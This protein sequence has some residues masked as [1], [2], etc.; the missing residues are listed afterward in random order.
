LVI[1]SSYK[2]WIKKEIAVFESK[3]SQYPSRLVYA[4]AIIRSNRWDQWFLNF[5]LLW[6]LMVIFILDGW[7]SKYSPVPLTIE[8]GI[9]LLPLVAMLLCQ[10]VPLIGTIYFTHYCNDLVQYSAS[11]N[12]LHW[13]GIA[14]SWIIF[15]M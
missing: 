10:A 7:A 5:F 2:S 6:L 15:P 1:P 9:V 11:E 8:E 12:I 14:I 13:V 4:L 3:W